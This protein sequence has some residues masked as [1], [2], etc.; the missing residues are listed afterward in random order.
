MRWRTG[1]RRRELLEAREEPATGRVRVRHRF[2]NWAGAFDVIGEM[3]VDR[4]AL[5]ARVWLENAP[6]PQP[7][8]QVYLE[9]VSAGTWSETA[10]ARI[11]RTGQC[12]REAASLPAGIRR[13]QSRDL[14]RGF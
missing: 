6:A 3:W 8:F 9:G 2:R 13:T 11:R 14:V 10:D 4:D 1:A 7:W 5:R 12:D